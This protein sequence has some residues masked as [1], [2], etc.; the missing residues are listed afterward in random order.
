MKSNYRNLYVQL[1]PLSGSN[2]AALRIKEMIIDGKLNT[3]EAQRAITLLPF[4]LKLPT[5]K[6]LTSYENLLADNDNIKFK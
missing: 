2:P 6:L 3:M 5:E 1:L 4:H